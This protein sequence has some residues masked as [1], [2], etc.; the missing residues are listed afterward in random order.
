MT[1]FT[2]PLLD[3]VITSRSMTT[4]DRI[5]MPSFASVVTLLTGLGCSA[6]TPPPTGA[7]VA[8]PARDSHED[9]DSPQQSPKGDTATQRP[10]FGPTSD[11]ENADVRARLGSIYKPPPGPYLSASVVGDP[12]TLLGALSRRPIEMSAGA[13]SASDPIDGSVMGKTDAHLQFV[14]FAGEAWLVLWVPSS[15]FTPRIVEETRLRRRLDTP[16]QDGETGIWLSPGAV[17]ERLESRDGFTKVRHSGAGPLI[18][19]TPSDNVGAFFELGKQTATRKKWFAK[20]RNTSLILKGG[21]SLTED[22]S[23]KGPILLTV[24]NEESV[25]VHK[26]KGKFALVEEIA[27]SQYRVFGWARR[28][29]LRKPQPS[30]AG[31]GVEG[32]VMGGVGPAQQP[33]AV[34]ENSCLYDHPDLGQLVGMTSG[35]STAPVGPKMSNGAQAIR[36]SVGQRVAT[37]YV[38]SIDNGQYEACRADTRW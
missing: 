31:G 33:D 20:E 35:A 14:F 22:R 6:N 13:S 26:K 21:K 27:T 10:D 7:E 5:R 9:T 11:R 3:V 23:G 38:K 34:P 36:L 29:D 1:V 19:W 24:A 16:P 28:T 18:G 4:I 37:L 30:G 17:V 32:G 25:Y 8:A 15:S 12:G 2:I